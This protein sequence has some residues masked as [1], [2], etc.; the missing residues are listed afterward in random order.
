LIMGLIKLYMKPILLLGGGHFGR[1]AGQK[2]KRMA[3]GGLL[4]G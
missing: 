3:A 4:V 1:G 2:L